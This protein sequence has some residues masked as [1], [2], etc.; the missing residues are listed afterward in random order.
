MSNILKAFI[1]I[2]NNYQTSI[3][4]V[5]QGNNRANNMGEGLETYIKDVFAS[6]TNETD[7]QT[8]LE[9]LSRIYSY[10]GNKNNPPDLMLK[11]SDAIEIKK[12]ESKN[13]AIAL[14]SSYPKA[15]FM[16]IVQ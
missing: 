14:N 3:T 5:T 7:E 8:K 9:K 11:N 10:Q 15:N 16:P 6:T 4:N 12:I 1:N 2:I 13:T